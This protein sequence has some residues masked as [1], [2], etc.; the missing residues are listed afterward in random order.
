MSAGH[1]TGLI[2]LQSVPHPWENEYLPG[3]VN[4]TQRGWTDGQG[5]WFFS[6]ELPLGLKDAGMAAWASSQLQPAFR[7]GMRGLVSELELLP[8]Q[9]LCSRAKCCDKINSYDDSLNCIKL[10][11]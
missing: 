9:E 5:G 2:D 1:M 8:G 3:K 6:A 10:N 7:R 11:Q 4:R